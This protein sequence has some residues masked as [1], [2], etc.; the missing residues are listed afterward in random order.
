MDL[1]NIK[2]QNIFMKDIYQ[3][4][5]NKVQVKKYI[6]IKVNTQDILKMTLSLVQVNMIG[7]IIHNIKV[8]LKMI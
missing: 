1:L 4:I 2:C 3:I 6:K 5:K 8:V 7:Q